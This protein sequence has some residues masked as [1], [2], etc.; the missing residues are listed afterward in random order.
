VCSASSFL[1]RLPP[2]FGDLH[3]DH[4]LP[5]A[6]DV[7]GGSVYF[8]EPINHK[9]GQLTDREP[10]RQQCGFG[11]AARVACQA[12]GVRGAVRRSVSPWLQDPM[13]G[14]SE[15]G[16]QTCNTD[17]DS[18]DHHGGLSV[19]QLPLHVRQILRLR[20]SFQFGRT[21]APTIPH[22]A[23]TIRGPKVGT[24][25]P[26]SRMSPSS[27][28]SAAQATNCHAETEKRP[29]RPSGVKALLHH[30]AHPEE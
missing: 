24:V 2:L 12:V 30:R 15:G 25:T 11:A 28:R 6:L 29:R 7:G 21:S 5:P 18:E 3:P 22:R 8:R 1:D 16:A 13:H 10:F 17:H 23:H 27:V 4:V 26:S 19:A 9:H 20:R 14:D